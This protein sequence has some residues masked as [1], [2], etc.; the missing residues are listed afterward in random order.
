M[1]QMRDLEELN[2]KG[3]IFKL[4]LKELIEKML[5]WEELKLDQRMKP[6]IY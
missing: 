2:W 5:I 3:K 1:N 4:K 6:R